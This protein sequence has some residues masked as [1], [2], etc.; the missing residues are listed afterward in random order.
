MESLIDRVISQLDTLVPFL[1][2]S[3]KEVFE[4]IQRHEADW[5]PP[6]EAQPIP[7]T[8]RM[9]QVQVS[10]AAFLLG[11]SYFEAFLAD[12]VKQI[13]Q[14]QPSML[15]AEKELKFKDLLDCDSYDK[16]LLLMVNK[17]VFALIY[18]SMEKIINYFDQ[19]LSIH[20]GDTSDRQDIIKAALLRNCLIHNM[21]R[22]DSRLA[23]VS[24]WSEGSFIDL[25][26]SEVHSFGIVGRRI[27]QNIYQQ[28]ETKFLIQSDLSA[29]INRNK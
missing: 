3:H 13:Y 7:D 11:Y 29:S 24:R 28:A 17:E 4:I 15:P 16:V 20:F 2:V 18:N 1:A 6:N 22:A 26:P 19:K 27:S 23:Y 9:Y 21:A 14:T 12:M 25:E 8:Y 5:F 10:H